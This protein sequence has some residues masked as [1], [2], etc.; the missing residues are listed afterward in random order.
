MRLTRRNCLKTLVAATLAC[1]GQALHLRSAHAGDGHD[2]GAHGHAQPGLSPAR[3]KER[4]ALLRQ[5]EAALQRLDTDAAQQALDN[6]AMIAHAADTELLLVRCYM[7][8]GEYRRALAF[9]AHTA[10]AH[11]EEVEGAALYAWLLQAGGQGAIAQRLLNEA[12]ARAHGHAVLDDVVAQLQS[13]RPQATR[14]LLQSP[15]RFAPCAS[16]AGIP[17]Q[18]RTVGSAVLAPDGRRA[19]VPATVLGKA[20]QGW[21][22]NGLGQ[23]VQA[24]VEPGRPGADLA[25]L[26]LERAL[27]VGSGLQLAARD[28]FPG[29]V[30]FAVEYIAGRGATPAWPVMTGGFIGSPLDAA[31]GRALGIDLVPG[32][33]GGPV[34]DAAGR[35]IGIA[36][37]QPG[38]DRLLSVSAL[39][40]VLGEGPAQQQAA[41]AGTAPEAIG[42]IYEQALRS[43]LQFIVA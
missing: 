30:G 9:C 32:P 17:S 7:Q 20:R 34:F 41:P 31:G 5:G 38:R 16:A 8:A 37:G 35:L 19:L 26:R 21:V 2:H 43:T 14:A 27:P 18:A 12:K 40:S 6:A 29:S 3:L 22:R 36:A 42:L 13:R 24:R 23:T 4:A 15:A 33:R 39:S 28:A 10:G 25:V 1:A 11:L